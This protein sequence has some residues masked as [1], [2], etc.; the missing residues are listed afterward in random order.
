MNTIGTIFRFTS[1]G[2]SHGLCV[3]GVV[4]GCPAGLLIDNDLIASDLDRRSG[5]TDS[6]QGGGRINQG[7][8]SRAIA[9][10]D[11]VEWLSGIAD[12]MTLG[13]PVTFIIRNRNLR[14]QDYQPLGDS[15]RAAHADYTYQMKYGIRD[16]R[17]GGRASAR[18]TAARVVAGSIAKQLLAQRGITVAAKVV[19]VGA[20]TDL[21]KISLLLKNLSASGDSIGGI[22]ECSIKGLPVG[23]GEPIFDKL[24]AR[25]AAAVM[26]INA[27]KGFEYGSGF[28][29]VG[30]SGR[31]MWGEPYMTGA[32]PVNSGGALGGISDGTDFLFRAVFKP[33]PSFGIAGRH[34]VCVALRVPVVVEAMAAMTIIDL[35]MSQNYRVCT[36]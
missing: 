36:D 14:G 1:F 31:Q 34:D 15:F 23:V 16:H 17:G 2:E 24:Q 4:D 33:T 30:M 11:E 19:Q 21:E 25:L 28:G 3:G 26:S 12:G 35:I 29:G 8:S 6:I 22:I 5:R 9:E 7:T 18:E 10:P 32:V 20:E 27:C 13:T